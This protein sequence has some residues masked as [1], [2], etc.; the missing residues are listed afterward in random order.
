M[1]MKVSLISRQSLLVAVATLFFYV[2]LLNRPHIDCLQR[3]D[4]PVEGI[5]CNAGNAIK[6]KIGLSASLDL[7]KLNP[8]ASKIAK[9]GYDPITMAAAAKHNLDPNLLRAII[10]VESN[11]QPKA[12]SGKG[13]GGLMQI[14]EETAQKL[15]IN[16]RFDPEQN[17]H[18][19]A[20]YIQKLLKIFKNDLNLALAAYNAGPAPVLKHK[21]IPP[22][23]QTQ[24]Y[25]K[26]V[27]LAYEEMKSA[28]SA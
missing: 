8:L 28:H 23:E 25:V 3:S 19:G 5:Q 7:T 1:P 14:T 26:K 6:N 4:G 22:Y 16:N 27:M 11:Y 21:G 18:G 20:K 10:L 15:G 12:V 2:L 24:K 17:I 9:S 13:A